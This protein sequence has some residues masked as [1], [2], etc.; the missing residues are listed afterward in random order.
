M[1]LQEFAAKYR[2]KLIS[3]PE[4]GGES[5]IIGRKAISTSTPLPSLVFATCLALRMVA[6]LVPGTRGYGMDSAELPKPLA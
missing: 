2:L 5:S 4:D 1:T 6:A 3:K